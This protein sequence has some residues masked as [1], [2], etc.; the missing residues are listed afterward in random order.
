[1][2]RGPA[3]MARPAGW[4]W[5]CCRKDTRA[6]GGKPAAGVV[7]PGAGRMPESAADVA[8]RQG[9]R[10]SCTITAAAISLACQRLLRRQ[11]HREGRNRRVEPGPL[12]AGLPERL[13]RRAPLLGAPPETTKG[14]KMSQSEL[15]E[16][17]VGQ[18]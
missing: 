1:P 8:N 17:E 2:P 12:H 18:D 4:I 13:S 10:L 14:S 15:T 11:Q 7:R 5:V 6:R 3:A 16:Y 9:L